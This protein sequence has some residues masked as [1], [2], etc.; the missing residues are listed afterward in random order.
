MYQQPDHRVPTRASCVG[1]SIGWAIKRRHSYGHNEE[2]MI[3][4]TTAL[5][6]VMLTFLSLGCAKRT[7]PITEQPHLTQP[8]EK[9]MAIKLTSSAFKDGQPIPRG[10]TCDGADVSPPLE[11]TD[12]PKSAKTIRRSGNSSGRSHASSSMCWRWRQ[13]NCVSLRRCRAA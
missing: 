4:R 13:P 1:W 5:G 9:K 8:G 3:K 10:Y 12:I 2:R 11:W 7:Q 6:C